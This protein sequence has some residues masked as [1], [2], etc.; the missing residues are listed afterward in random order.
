M[1]QDELIAALKKDRIESYA[2]LRGGFPLP[3]AGGIYWLVMGV[4]G[5]YL[6]YNTWLYVV[7]FG[8]G[9]IFP[10][11]LLLAK[12]FH[13]NF[14]KD[15]QAAS[16][17][18]LPALIGMLLFWPALIASMQVAPQLAILILAIGMGAHWPVVGWSYNRTGLFTAHSL[19]RAAGVFAIW[20]YLP[21]A[22]MTLLP[23]AVAALYFLTV[24]VILADT[25]MLR[26]KI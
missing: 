9:L 13:N 18:I 1:T 6:P 15:K 4:M 8:T 14:L 26:K 10:V 20:T 22:R 19:I 7:F 24:L 25:A 17:V 23:F 2:R 3:L 11:S 5:Y 16:S 12:V 21:D